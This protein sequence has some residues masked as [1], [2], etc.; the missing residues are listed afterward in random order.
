MPAPRKAKPDEGVR[1]PPAT[2][3]EGRENELIALSFDLA[4][5]QLREGKAS[6]QVIVH[7]LKR[8]SLR[9]KL[10]TEK[11]RA[12]NDLLRARIAQ[13]GQDGKQE[14]LYREAINAMREYGGQAETEEYDG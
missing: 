2:T 13:A 1:R 5:Q 10:E 9:D 7:Y 6:T 4:E 12:E 3:P 8:G 14:E 11:L